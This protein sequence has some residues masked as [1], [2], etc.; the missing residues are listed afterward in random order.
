MSSWCIGSLAL[1]RFVVSIARD[2][3]R[4]HLKCIVP[5]VQLSICIHIWCGQEINTLASG[6]TIADQL[7]LVAALPQLTQNDCAAILWTNCA[8]MCYSDDFLCYN[9]LQYSI[10]NNDNLCCFMWSCTK[11]KTENVQ[12]VHYCCTIQ[13]KLAE[14]VYK[15]VFLSSKCIA[16]ALTKW[17]KPWLC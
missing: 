5:S 13:F 14:N 15:I 3:H 16:N 1:N 4:E 10:Q 12:L 9:V 2:G 6:N 11:E 7:A 17:N 8:T